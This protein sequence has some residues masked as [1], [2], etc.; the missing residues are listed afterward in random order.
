MQEVD[1]SPSGLSISE[2]SLAVPVHELIGRNPPGLA[3]AR[4]GARSEGPSFP[5]G[6][7][8]GRGEHRRDPGLSRPPLREQRGA[9]TSSTSA[10]EAPRLPRGH[11]GCLRTRT[12]TLKP[13]PAVFRDSSCSRMTTASALGDL[14]PLPGHVLPSRRA[15][16][17]QSG[18]RGDVSTRRLRLPGSSSVRP[19][20]P[21]S[22]CH[23]VTLLVLLL[24]RVRRF[25]HGRSRTPLR[26]AAA[27]LEQRPSGSVPTGPHSQ[28]WPRQP[29]QRTP[30]P[31]PAAPGP[32][33][34][35]P[36]AVSQPWAPRADRELQ[37]D[38]SGGPQASFKLLQRALQSGLRCP[39]TDG[40]A[41]A[42][43]PAPVPIKM[44]PPLQDPRGCEFCTDGQDADPRKPPPPPG[45]PAPSRVTRTHVPAGPQYRG[46]STPLATSKITY[47]KRKLVEED[48]VHPPLSCTHKTIS[49]FEERAHI[50]YMSL[51]KLKFIDDP[52][53][54]LRRSVLI[55]N[56][57]KRIHGEIITHSSWCFPACAFHGAPAAQEWFGVQDCP[58][59]KRPRVARD[60]RERPPACCVYQ[61]PSCP[62]APADLLWGS[63]FFVGGITGH[64][65]PEALP[66][67]RARVTGRR[68]WL[69]PSLARTPRHSTGLSSPTPLRLAVA[70]ARRRWYERLTSAADHGNDGE[71]GGHGHDRCQRVL[72]E[73]LAPHSSP[74]SPDAPADWNHPE[75]Q[76][77]RRRP[78][79]PSGGPSVRG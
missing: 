49:V 37:G 59:R 65:D 31:A 45:T 58:Y 39:V 76:P 29:V 48:D 7:R 8:D 42:E 26:Q 18:C 52:E 57:M 13:V 6:S 56:L 50:L 51:E 44:P 66:R 40:G 16:A 14:Q 34:L 30:S 60:Q 72:G 36:G 15:K 11:D 71:H 61:E 1:F 46:V 5:Q 73:R 54:Y 77:E 21:G 68:R 32:H 10:R 55:N 41:W 22:W 27:G 53:A 9:F 47:V 25:G 38:L 17:P 24:E 2:R 79:S 19:A 78:L 23:A 33:P 75:K 64:D 20:A 4:V 69:W 12:P 63:G 70:G 3:L 43:R 74:A 67:G 28:T 62:P 35:P